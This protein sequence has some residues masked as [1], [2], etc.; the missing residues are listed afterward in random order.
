MLPIEPI[1]KFGLLYAAEK[2]RDR[3]RWN[4]FAS[5][6]VYLIPVVATYFLAPAVI[7]WLAQLSTGTSSAFFLPTPGWSNVVEW[8]INYFVVVLTLGLLAR[9]EDSIATW[10]A[11]FISGFIVLAFVL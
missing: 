9:F 1:L 6:L 5:G 8:V 2:T 4:I 10:L 3:K 7:G 11:I